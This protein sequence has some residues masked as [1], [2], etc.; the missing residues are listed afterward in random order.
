MAKP[1]NGTIIIKKI[2]KGG[3]A[4]HHGGAWKVAYAD[5]VTAM[6]AFFLLLWLRGSTNENQRKGLADYFGASIA[7]DPAFVRTAPKTPDPDRRLDVTSPR[8]LTASLTMNGTVTGAGIGE[9]N[10]GK[11]IVA[12]AFAE[13]VS[14][15]GTGVLELEDSVGYT[16]KVLGLSNAGTNSL[17]LTDITFTSGV[18]KATYS[19]T[20]ASGTLTVTDGTH[21]AHIQLVGNYTT[22]GAFVLSSD[23]HGGTTV[24]DPRPQAPAVLTQAMASFQIE[25]AAN[26]AGPSPAAPTN[27]PLIAAHG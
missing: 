21:T 2:K 11:L 27:L 9:I 14:F 1:G 4:A 12:Q 6:M 23:G 25:A 13:N 19:G 7:N 26:P 15:L 5:F 24:I 22:A 3:H 20:T 16:G 10:G 18:T 8:C 17:D